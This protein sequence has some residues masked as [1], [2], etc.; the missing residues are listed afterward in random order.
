MKNLRDIHGRTPLHVA[1]EK[2]ERPMVL[3]A[4]GAKVDAR[5]VSGRTPLHCS[6]E[7]GYESVA[8]IL[9]ENGASVDPE[10]TYGEAYW[11]EESSIVHGSRVGH[12]YKIGG[13]TPLHVAAWKGYEEVARV[14]IRN[15]ADVNATNDRSET[16]LKV[17]LQYGKGGI[18]EYLKKR[19]G[20]KQV[21]SW[22]G[23]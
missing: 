2:G 11:K 20:E 5:D 12:K 10:A 18:A 13:L 3:L 21:S 1:A 14:L 4:H 19:G 15:E 7:K 8:E 22:W 16:P 17:S 9:L 6:A 23:W